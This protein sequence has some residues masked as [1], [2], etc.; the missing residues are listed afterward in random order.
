MLSSSQLYWHSVYGFL[1]CLHPLNL[2]TSAKKI[3]LAWPFPVKNES[4]VILPYYLN[5]EKKYIVIILIL[6]FM[7]KRYP[8]IINFLKFISTTRIF[9]CMHFYLMMTKREIFE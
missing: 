5:T 9:S 8:Q 2:E 6:K 1:I 3:S 7:Y 4:E